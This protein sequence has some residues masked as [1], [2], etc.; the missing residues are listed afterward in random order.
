[1]VGG[2]MLNGWGA[3]RAETVRR[4]GMKTLLVE[5]DA[6]LG[7]NL[8]Q[9]LQ[10]SGFTVDWVEGVGDADA[11]L[12]ANRYDCVVLDLGLPDGDGTE[13]LKALRS[14]RDRTPTLVLTARDKLDDTVR[15]LN[16]GA[17]DYLAKPFNLEELRARLRALARRADGRTSDRLS[18]SGLSLDLVQR[19][20]QRDEE[21]IP[22]TRREFKVLAELMRRP[23]EFVPKSR[24]EAALYD[25]ATSI[26]SNTVEAI[27]YALRRKLGSGVI[28]MARGV[29]YMTPK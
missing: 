7:P 26:E 3:E 15:S 14:R 27:I 8:K 10:K 20:L 28:V 17:D 29:G 12:R 19:R 9:A 18:A 2:V 13:V 25:D 6:M 5:D 16:I 11:A 22:L 24:L 1:M 4:A 21:E 23:G